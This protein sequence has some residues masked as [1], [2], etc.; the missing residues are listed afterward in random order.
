MRDGQA[1][2]ANPKVLGIGWITDCRQP[3][4][5]YNPRFAALCAVNQTATRKSG[6]NQWGAA[7]LA[8]PATQNTQRT[9][10]Y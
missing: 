7:E 2:F 3:F 10:R 4:D 9:F 1:G 8:A 6:K 5:N